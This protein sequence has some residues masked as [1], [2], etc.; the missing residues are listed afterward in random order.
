MSFINESLLQLEQLAK[1]KGITMKKACAMAGISPS[2][3]SRWKHGKQSP[4]MLLF[5]RLHESVQ[6]YSAQKDVV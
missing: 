4:Q 6:S 1:E 3:V 5:Q 2:T